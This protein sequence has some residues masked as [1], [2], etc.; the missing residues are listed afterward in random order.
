MPMRYRRPDLRAICLAAVLALLPGCVSVFDQRVVAKSDD[1]L[2]VAAGDRDDLGSLAAAF[3]GDETKGWLIAEFNGIKRVKA[4]Q[5]IVIPLRQTNRAAIYG[6][7]FV[8]VPILTY[9]HFTP[10]GRKCRQVAVSAKAFEA[11]LAYLKKG[12]VDLL[13]EAVS[14]KLI[15]G[16]SG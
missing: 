4:G 7:G 9:H 15:L 6:D 14:Y 11:Q 13:T 8:K 1:F 2:V 10:P 16:T 12:V 5:E 3:L